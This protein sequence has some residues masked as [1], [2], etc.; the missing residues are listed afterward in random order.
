MRRSEHRVEMRHDE[1][2][3]LP[4]QLQ[5]PRSPLQGGTQTASRDQPQHNNHA[6]DGETSERDRGGDAEPCYRQSQRP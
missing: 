2:V 4:R 1:L 6:G 3:L 5:L